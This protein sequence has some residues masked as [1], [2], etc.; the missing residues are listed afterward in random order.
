MKLGKTKYNQ[1]ALYFVLSS[2]VVFDDQ[3]VVSQYIQN[4]DIISMLHL[5]SLCGESCFILS[6]FDIVIS[7]LYANVYIVLVNPSLLIN[8]LAPDPIL[9]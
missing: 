4:C 8:P 5:R 3:S 1:L 2:L 7:L 6:T 9:Q